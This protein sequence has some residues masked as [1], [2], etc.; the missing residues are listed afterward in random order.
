MTQLTWTIDVDGATTHAMYDPSPD[1]DHAAVFVCAHGAGGNMNAHEAALLD[2]LQVVARNTSAT[3]V[4]VPALAP[5]EKKFADDE[6]GAQSWYFVLSQRLPLREALATADGWGGDDYVAF[7]RSG[8]TRI[9]KLILN[10]S[11]M[12]PG[13]VSTAV[14]VVTGLAIGRLFF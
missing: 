4:S 1:G 6:F 13:L 14:A 11:F 12:I 8:T 7:D 3:H 9:G 5:G 10:H 2:P